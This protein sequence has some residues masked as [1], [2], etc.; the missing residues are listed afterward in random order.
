MNERE[1]AHQTFENS[2]SR[3]ELQADSSC[4]SWDFLAQLDEQNGHGG[5]QMLFETAL[6]SL[7]SWNM[8]Q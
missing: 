5:P 2:G 1:A 7:G 4:L 3:P 8:L 6:R